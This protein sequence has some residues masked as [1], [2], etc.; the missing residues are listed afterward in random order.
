MLETKKCSGGGKCRGPTD[1][2]K[3]KKPP[4]KEFCTQ[5]R[6]IANPLDPSSLRPHLGKNRSILGVQGR[7]DQNLWA[8]GSEN[9]G[10]NRGEK[11][12]TSQPTSAFLRDTGKLQDLD[13][14]EGGWGIQIDHEKREKK[15]GEKGRSCGIFSR[16][17]WTNQSNQRK[18]GAMR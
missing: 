18:G 13:L 9:E 14:G 1:V 10:G 8:R 15:K 5:V 17:D 6:K 4:R 12:K 11:G 7:K 3:K 2:E 16:S